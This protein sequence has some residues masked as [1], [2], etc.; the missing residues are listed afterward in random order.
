[1]PLANVEIYEYQIVLS[2]LTV[3][4]SE[5]IKKTGAQGN[6]R[7]EGIN[8]NKGLFVLGQVVSALSERSSATGPGRRPPYRESKLTRLLQDSLGGNSRTIMVACVS[9]ADINVEESI[10]TLRYATCARKIKSNATRNIIKNISPEEAAALRR[11]NQ[12][13][14][15]E[16]LELRE[17][18]KRLTQS[19]LGTSD[20]SIMS[21]TGDSC[22]DEDDSFALRRQASTDSTEESSARVAALEKQVASLK[23]KLRN[24]Q[25]GLQESARDAAVELPAAKVELA[26]L[27]EKLQ[28]SRTMEEENISLIHQLEEAR[29][30]ADSARI[31][32]AKLS[33]ILDQLKELRRDEI[34]KKK[35]ELKYMKKDEAWVVFMDTL[36]EGRGERMSSLSQDFDLVMK[37]VENPSAF[38]QWHE[39]KTWW[40]KRTGETKDVLTPELRQR[41]VAEHLDFFKI[42]L[43]ETVDDIREESDSLK[44]MRR[45]IQKDCVTMQEEIGKDESKEGHFEKV[46]KRDML[47]KLKKVWAS[48]RSL[49]SP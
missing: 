22:K 28:Q 38:S 9:P 17:T 40:G 5:R 16:V 4:G 24:S 6:R 18:V 8:I 11:E 44:Q 46:G 31:A 48:N 25:V 3:I 7:Q 49:A 37:V 35:E 45:S 13:L 41:V 21:S 30:D 14:Q 43:D 42:R 29:A 36:L 26:L 20:G 10:N 34:D 12:L 1:M 33:D 23:R 47:A 2:C 32:A 15:N 39:T 19:G 27:R